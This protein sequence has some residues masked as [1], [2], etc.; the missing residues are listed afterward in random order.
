[1]APFP[2]SATFKHWTSVSTCIS[3]N[4]IDSIRNALK[5]MNKSDWIISMPYCFTLHTA[6][7]YKN[8]LPDCRCWMVSGILP[9]CP[10]SWSST[11]MISVVALFH[12]SHIFVYR[13]I[14]LEDSYNDRDLEKI[15][16]KLSADTFATKTDASLLL[17]REIG[18]MYTAS[19]YSCII[20][21]LLRYVAV[22]W[23]LCFVQPS[24]KLL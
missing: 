18:N 13:N 3:I 4:W 11:S 14:K 21:Y 10:P 7:L 12:N 15:L 22:L 6:S 23:L 19:L 2:I 16:L 24:F 5:M 20:S 1:M 17:P 9:I 8:R